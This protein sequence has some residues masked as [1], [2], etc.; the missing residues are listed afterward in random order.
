[1]P[2]LSPKVC[3]YEYD[4]SLFLCFEFCHAVECA[5]LRTYLQ[6]ILLQ[7]HLSKLLEHSWGTV[8]ARL[9]RSVCNVKN[10]VQAFVW[11]RVRTLVKSQLQ[12]TICSVG[13]YTSCV[14]LRTIV[15][16]LASL[17]K[18]Y[19]FCSCT[20]CG[21]LGQSTSLRITRCYRCT[22]IWS[23]VHFCCQEADIKYNCNLLIYHVHLIH[24]LFV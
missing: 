9:G 1:M 13:I 11:A 24:S 6:L 16:P 8:A 10:T 5:T 18:G 4:C 23:C 14:A 2:G 22:F 3:A 21:D 7:I 17:H 15:W 20:Q 19:G 12:S